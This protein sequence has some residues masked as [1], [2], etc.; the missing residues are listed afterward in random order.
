MLKISII[1]REIPHY[2]IPFFSQVHSSAAKLDLD[3]TVYSGRVPDKP[4]EG[5]RCRVVQ[6]ASVPVAT[7]RVCWMKGLSSAVKGSAAV[8]APQELQCLTVPYLWAMRRRIC[9]RWIW[10]GHGWNHQQWGRASLVELAKRAI[11]ERGDG[12]ITYTSEGAKYWIKRGLPSNRVIPY[13]NTIDV[14]GI[15]RAAERITDEAL[16]RE[17]NRLGLEGRSVLLFSGRLYREKRV[18]FLLRSFAIMQGRGLPVGLL[19]IGD[20][21]ERR[22]LEAQRERMGLR[23]VHFLGAQV[24]AGEA[25][26]YFRLADLLVIPGLV[27]LAIVHGFA[28]NLPLVTTSHPFH[29][30]EIEYLSTHNGV[31]TSHDETAYAEAIEVLLSEPVTLAAMRR[32][33]AA[34]ADQLRMKDSADRFVGAI[35]SVMEMKTA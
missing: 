28:L 19:V 10:W 31:M 14:D 21:P 12:L 27:G 22:S 17:R 8:V 16:F 24:G 3:V 4:A 2:R 33:A 34:S 13:F 7:A 5:F 9:D 26:M 23:D 30:P 25:G 18:D 1:Q 15:R 6:T 35:L 32:S 20:G 29:S 11:T